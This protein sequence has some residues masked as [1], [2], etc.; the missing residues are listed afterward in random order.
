MRKIVTWNVNAMW[1]NII[2]N[3]CKKLSESIK[4]LKIDSV[5]SVDLRR[6]MDPPMEYV[7]VRL[8]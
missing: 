8:L 6:Y 1:E 3:M 4:P 2:L 5:H 7:W